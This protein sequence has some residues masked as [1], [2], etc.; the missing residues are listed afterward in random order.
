MKHTLSWIKDTDAGKVDLKYRRVISDTLDPKE[1][2]SIP[3]KKRV[4]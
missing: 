3:P 1:M 4:Y 2:A